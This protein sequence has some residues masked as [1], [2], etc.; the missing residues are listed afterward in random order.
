MF[1]PK[2]TKNKNKI[3]Y[4]VE[5]EEKLRR[6]K[7]TIEAK[8]KRNLR[9]ASHINTISQKVLES[10]TLFLGKNI[11]KQGDY[12]KVSIKSNLFSNICSKSVKL[13]NQITLSNF[14][15]I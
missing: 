4:K 14:N 10:L 11:L 3:G 8:N 2:K 6:R 15:R 12:F 13:F 7:R 1:F 5:Q 9:N